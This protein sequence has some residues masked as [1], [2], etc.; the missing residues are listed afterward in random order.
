MADIDGDGR[1]DLVAT[2]Q[3]D[4]LI[5]IYRNPSVIGKISLDQRRDF[6]TGNTPQSVAV[7]DYDGDGLID[8][9]VATDPATRFRFSQRELT[10]C[11][12][13]STQI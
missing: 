9:A 2:P 4:G 7:A 10:R 12:Q 5:S 1:P 13:A 8:L 3:S 6:A 11:H